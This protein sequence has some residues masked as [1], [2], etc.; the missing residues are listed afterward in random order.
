MEECPQTTRVSTQSGVGALAANPLALHV[1][2]LVAVVAHQFLEVVAGDALVGG[3]FTGYGQ[4]ELA[5]VVVVRVEAVEDADILAQGGHF[6]ARDGRLE[7]NLVEER[8]AQ[9]HIQVVHVDRVDE[10]Q[11]FGALLLLLLFRLLGRVVLGED[12]RH[13]DGQRAQV[14]AHRVENASAAGRVDGNRLRVGWTLPALLWPEEGEHLDGGYFVIASATGRTVEHTFHGHAGHVFQVED[15]FAADERRLVLDDQQNHSLGGVVPVEQQLLA[16]V[17]P[18]GV[19]IGDQQQVRPFRWHHFFFGRLEFRDDSVAQC[20]DLV[21][22][23]YKLFAVGHV[24]KVWP[25][26]PDG[27]VTHDFVVATVLG[28]RIIGA[29][30][31]GNDDHIFPACKVVQSRKILY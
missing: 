1:F 24:H 16:L 2:K 7:R 13:V 9:R 3:Q 17:R 14:P 6:V 11:L 22:T 28:V 27:R 12:V 4:Q 25:E 19:F 10:A 31:C 21:V 30:D 18:Q 23:S 29:V 15:E 8:V 5:S 20:T 26:V